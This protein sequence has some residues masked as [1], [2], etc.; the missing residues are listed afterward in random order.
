MT[1]DEQLMEAFQGGDRDAYQALYTRWS[2]RILRFL[3]RRLGGLVPAEDALQET[4]L[5]VYRYRDR[6][7]PGRA[8]RPWLFTIASNVGKRAWRP[9]PET[10]EWEPRA[11][12]HP[13]LRDYLVRALGELE[14]DERR[15]LLLGIEGFN[16]TEIGEMLEIKP[17]A[18]R[19]RLKRARDKVKAVLGGLHGG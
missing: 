13:D 10:F 3:M 6:Y 16:S 14:E 1:T 5:R 15:I 8:F 12:D 17:S 9:E 18:V 11:E 4:F 19:M 7:T 2:P